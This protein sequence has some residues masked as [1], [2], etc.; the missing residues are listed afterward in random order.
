MIR[1][2]TLC[3]S[4]QISGTCTDRTW[5]QANTLSPNSAPQGGLTWKQVFVHIIV[6]N[7]VERVA[8]IQHDR[9]LIRMRDIWTD[10]QE[11]L[12][13]D[14]GSDGVIYKPGDQGTRRTDGHHQELRALGSILHL[15]PN[16]PAQPP[17]GS[18]LPASEL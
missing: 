14:R 11:R 5:A 8:L 15:L 6:H 1:A 10:T 18:W 12:C 17:P 9:V 16:G 4:A 13:E 3:G 7:E 2:T